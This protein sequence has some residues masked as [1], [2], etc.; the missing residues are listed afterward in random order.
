MKTPRSR[1][2]YIDSDILRYSG[3]NLVRSQPAMSQIK[4]MDDFVS[5]DRSYNPCYSVNVVQPFNGLYRYEYGNP[6][7]LE[8]YVDV[9]FLYYHMQTFNE[10]FTR[11]LDELNVQLDFQKNND[12]ELLNLLGELDDLIATFTL[13]FWKQLTYGAFNW[14]I[15]PLISDLK[16]LSASFDD[17]FNGGIASAIDSF[18]E[19]EYSTYSIKL[20]G[21]VPGLPR[22]T[23]EFKGKLRLS[24]SHHVS[25]PSS[26]PTTALQLFLDELGV[27]PDLRTIWDLIPLSFV[28]DYFLPIGDILESAHP[29]GWFRPNFYFSGSASLSGE[30]T[31]KRQLQFEQYAVVYP[32]DSKSRCYTRT[33]SISSDLSYRDLGL[34][35]NYKFGLS[36]RQLF[37][38][39]YLAKN[40]L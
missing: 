6:Y 15:L 32:D 24:G 40:V 22:H 29:R 10:C 4:Y 20:D 14:G 12:F 9:P 38:L 30:L 7:V 17:V 11:A 26:S 3:P 34:P 16:S 33:Q 19:K 1:V 31:L 35:N 25:F 5:S 39:G 28:L 18:N 23:Y 2:E 36:L 13:K 37:N 27:H 8:R 21:L